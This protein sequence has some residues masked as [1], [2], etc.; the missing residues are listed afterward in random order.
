MALKLIFMGTP[1]FAVP[2]L[3][4]I[5]RSN[6]N[7]LSVYT[8]SPKKSNRGQRINYTPVHEFSNKERIEVRCPQELNDLELEYIKR[9]NPDVIV[10]AAYGKILPEK[11]LN[12]KNINFFNVHASLLPKWRGAAPIQRSIIEMDKETGISIMKI[13]T[14]LDAGP[15]ILQ[16]KIKIDNNDNYKTLSRKLST[17]GSSMMLKSLELIEKKDYNLTYQ[18]ES[19]ATYAKKIDKKESQIQ[20]H[21]PSKN[22]VAKI[23]GLNPSPGIWFKHNN[24]RLRVIE[25]IEVEASGEA[26][27]VLDSKLTVACKEN[28]IRITSIQKEGKK[29]LKTKEFLAGYKIVKG[30]KLI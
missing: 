17:L 23:K 15:F 4:S 1:D 19:L 10:V 27:L 30:E 9:L 25:A 26:G 5:Q 11:F 20:W 21:I 24:S 13:V 12:I 6:H 14:K 18:D 16:E 8:Q 2:I 28:A 22:L 7:I 29:I 3:E